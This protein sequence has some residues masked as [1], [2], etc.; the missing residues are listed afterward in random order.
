MWIRV[1]LGSD[2][3]VVDDLNEL[4][5][6]LQCR[7]RA[8]REGGGGVSGRKWAPQCCGVLAYKCSIILGYY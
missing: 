1:E 3:V 2:F 6:W 4:L 5:T 8:V 7:R